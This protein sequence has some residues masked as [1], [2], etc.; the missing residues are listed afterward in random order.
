MPVRFFA[1]TGLFLAS[2]FVLLIAYFALPPFTPLVYEDKPAAVLFSLLPSNHLPTP[3]PLKALYLTSYAAG[4]KAI[5]EPV[6]KLIK[7]TEANAVVIDIKDYSGR[8]SFPLDDA[9]VKKFGAIDSRV[10]DI[11]DLIKKIHEDGVYA[12]GRI[13]VFQDPFIA[14]ERPELAVKRKSNPDLVWQD[15]K[16]ISWIDPGNEE[17]WRYIS[18]LALASYKIGFDE[19]NFDYIRFP[20]DGDMTDVFYPWSGSKDKTDVLESF[21]QFLAGEL[22]PRGVVISAD[23]FGMT[24]TNTD[25]LNIGQVL[26]NTLAHFDYAAPMVYPSH[27]PPTFLGL[28]NPA[29]HPY[30]VVR[31][32]MEEAMRRASTTP[33]KLRP[34][35]QDFNLG[36]PY[37]PDMIRAEKQAVYDAGFDSWML[38]NSRSVYTG[39]ALDK[40]TAEE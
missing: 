19:I 34:W 3:K 22:K 12:I 5:R 6:L 40:E 2:S 35:L 25:D 16:G 29:A 27:Y 23:L 32:S 17:Y 11:D 18:D 24:T 7:E 31:Y 26:E 36:A 4:S 39:G 10:P 21:F 28:G 33:W 14:R 30:K 15:H 9:S 20:S 13:S 1:V 37:T 38:W 8:V